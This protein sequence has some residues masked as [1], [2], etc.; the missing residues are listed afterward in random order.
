MWGSCRSCDEDYVEVVRSFLS[1]YLAIA[2]GYPRVMDVIPVAHAESVDAVAF[3][4]ALAVLRKG[5]EKNLAQTG[6]GSVRLPKL[7]G[8]FPSLIWSVMLLAL[9][10]SSFA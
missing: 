6:N 5:R 8:F 1:I 4:L 10:L 9:S 3:V 2:E 7:S